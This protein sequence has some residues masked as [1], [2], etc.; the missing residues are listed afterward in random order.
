MAVTDLAVG[1]TFA[2]EVYTQHV[3]GGADALGRAVAISLPATLI[4]VLVVALLLRRWEGRLAV[5][6]TARP[7]LEFRLG[8]CRRPLGVGAGLAIAICDGVPWLIVI[9]EV[10]G[11]AGVS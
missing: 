5:T 7:T 6:A 8:W 2:E 10:G 9:R 4:S 1:R 3:A 11:S